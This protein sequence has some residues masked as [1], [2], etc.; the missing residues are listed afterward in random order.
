MSIFYSVGYIRHRKIERNASKGKH[1]LSVELYKP[2]SCLVLRTNKYTAFYYFIIDKFGAVS[3][4][5]SHWFLCQV[6][7]TILPKY[8]PLLPWIYKWI[9]YYSVLKGMSTGIYTNRA[10]IRLWLGWICVS[11][12]WKE[13]CTPYWCLINIFE[14]VYF[15]AFWIGNT[16]VHGSCKMTVIWGS[17]WAYAI[18]MV[19]D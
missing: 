12:C 1:F 8:S 9:E 15:T 16:L 2:T 18:G 4:L 10:F 7:W 14:N 5:S 17:S 19:I 3:P 13:S 11:K 6:P